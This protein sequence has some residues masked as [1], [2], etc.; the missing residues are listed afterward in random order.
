MKAEEEERRRQEEAEE[1]A[2]TQ[3]E[4]ALKVGELFVMQK[5]VS[6]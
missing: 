1:D 5:W 6:G 3:L 2:I 4:N